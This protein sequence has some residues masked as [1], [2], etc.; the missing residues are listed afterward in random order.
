MKKKIIFFHPYSVLGGA[1]LSI[2]KLIDSTS[3]EYELEFLTISK[4]PKINFYSKRNIKIC[5]IKFYF[6]KK[7]N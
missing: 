7:S 4:Q 2:S 1:D 3:E 6:S 5:K